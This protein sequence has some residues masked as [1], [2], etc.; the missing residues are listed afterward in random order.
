LKKTHLFDFRVF[1]P[2]K[3]LV[4]CGMFGVVGCKPL[5]TGRVSYYFTKKRLKCLAYL[6]ELYIIA[7]F[8]LFYSY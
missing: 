7:S 8:Q 1:M 4:I 3:Q 2:I 5:P 6:D